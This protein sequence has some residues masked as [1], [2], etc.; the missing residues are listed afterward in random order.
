MISDELLAKIDQIVEEKVSHA[1]AQLKVSPEPIDTSQAVTSISK[2]EPKTTTSTS[3]PE[4]TVEKDWESI[5]SEDLKGK[6]TPGSAEEKIRRTVKAI[7]EHNDYKAPSNNER[8]FIGVRSIQDLSGCNYT[9]IKKYVDDHKTM[10]DDHNVKYGL[11]NQH[12]KKHKQEI[13]LVIRW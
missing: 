12:N 10:I 4:K 2:P 7:M 3:E 13:G 5:P 9:P 8:W 6:H 1:I 11:S